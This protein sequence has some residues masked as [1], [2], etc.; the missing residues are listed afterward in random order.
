MASGDGLPAQLL[1]V[2]DGCTLNSVDLPASWQ[3]D[4]ARVLAIGAVPRVLPNTDG[5][6]STE[7]DWQDEAAMRSFIQF[8]DKEDTPKAWR[9]ALSS[10]ARR[11]SD[12]ARESVL[13]VLSVLHC[14]WQATG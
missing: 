12:G 14:M 4:A 6:D 3:D 11:A 10:P 8:L 5:T 13:S 9:A 1:Q 7:P 2:A